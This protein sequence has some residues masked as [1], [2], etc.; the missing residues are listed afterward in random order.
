MVVQTIIILLFALFFGERILFLVRSWRR[1]CQKKEQMQGT[2]TE[3][4]GEEISL[5]GW[6]T[7]LEK[8]M[9]GYRFFYEV[10]RKVAPLLER[11]QL[12][13]VFSTEVKVLGEI[14]DITFSKSSAREGYLEYP[15]DEDAKEVVCVK[16]KSRSVIEHFPSL[17]R[18]LR[19]CLER[20]SLYARLQQLSIYD[21]LTEVYNRRYFMMRYLE[22]FKRSDKFGLNLSFLM[23]DIDYFKRI[24][25]TY[26]HLVGDVVLKEVAR[27]IK[28]NIREIDFVARFGGEEFAVIL[29][30]TDKGGAIMLGERICAKVCSEK[31]RAFDEV[32]TTTT[33]I[34]AAS[35]PQNTLH[36]DVLIEIADKALYKA[37]T[38]GR[39]RV[40][41]F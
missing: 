35:Y 28:E 16:T 10:A 34:G 38:A 22:E 2:F 5:K 15:L 12:L 39:N 1:Q 17:I 19:L 32:L 23:I 29:T 33:S 13:R 20:V 31:I 21:T 4:K 14:E 6:I 3:L 41:W 30:D 36:F 9:S 7:N 18:L 11:E 25:D 8:E 26:G 24:N 27:L 40:N 37:K